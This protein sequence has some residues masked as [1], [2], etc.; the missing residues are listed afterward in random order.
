MRVQK[1]IKALIWMKPISEFAEASKRHDTHYGCHAFLQR[2]YLFVTG[3]S[4]RAGL[5]TIP[6]TASIQP[7]TSVPS[8]QVASIS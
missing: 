4:I 8:W 3:N 2:N 7:V 5:R 6:I 1:M